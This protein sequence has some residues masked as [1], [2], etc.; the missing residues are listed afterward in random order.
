MN[1]VE[2]GAEVAAK[3]NI[4]KKQAEEIITLIFNNIIVKKV[5]SGED[6]KIAGFGTF[7]RKTRAARTGINPQT[8][9]PMKIA[10]SKAVSFKASATFKAAVNG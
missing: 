8:K 7:G 5:K 6:V 3:A 1:K 9:Q 4:T 2:L 10:A